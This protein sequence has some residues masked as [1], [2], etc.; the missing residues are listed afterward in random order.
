M[1]EGQEF[2]F[3]SEIVVTLRQVFIQVNSVAW[4]IEEYLLGK[5][6]TSEPNSCIRR[7]D[8]PSTAFI[9]KTNQKIVEN[10]QKG[11]KKRRIFK[12]AAFRKEPVATF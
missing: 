1:Y 6:I 7:N 9:P 10:L 5:H 11:K 12:K 8:L 4:N 2:F 3:F